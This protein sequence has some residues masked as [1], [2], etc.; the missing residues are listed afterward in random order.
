MTQTQ[1]LTSGPIARQ[2]V[3]LALPLLIG[4]ILQQ[5]YNTLDSFIVGRYVG[6]DSFAAIGI[7]GTV[8]NLF[9]F[10]LSGFCAGISII[11]AQFFGRDDF[12][13]FR[14]EVWLATALG[15]G[16]TAVISLIGFAAMSP[17]L[18]LIQTPADLHTLV[19]GYL[20]IIFLGL[21]TTYLYNL[22][23]AAL[24]S[25]GN[26][27]AALAAL[28]VAMAANLVLDLLFVVRFGMG[29]AGAA[30]ATVLAQLLS[31]ILCVIYWKARFPHLMCGP[32]DLKYDHQLAAQSANYGLV[33]ALHQS[34]LYIGKLLVQ[35][36]VNSMGTQVIAAYTATT[37]I[38]G[39]ANSFGD[40]G[41]AALSIFVAQNEGAGKR[42]RTQKGFRTGFCL[43]MGLVVTISVIMAL[44]AAPCSTLLI[45]SGQEASVASAIG[46]LRL[47]SVFYFLCFVGNVFVGYYR[48]RGMVQVPVIGTCL[49]ITVRVILSYLLAG[50]MGLRAVALATGIGWM[51]VVAYHSSVYRR[52]RKRDAAAQ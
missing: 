51:F 40:S 4:N 33:S 32:A 29:V 2:L 35:G 14:Q 52:L 45:G 46:Y 19:A 26:S 42:E 18:R 8:M 5:F 37:R 47:I 49:H 10:V 39:F 36:A 34:S 38:E 48:G 30:L 31:V 44:L 9:V 20:R 7:A 27:A 16:S 17:L 41:S 3:T 6:L 23:A 22:C 13:G 11:L 1:N 12:A 25:A 15:V 24:R 21:V 28:A 43:M 50:R